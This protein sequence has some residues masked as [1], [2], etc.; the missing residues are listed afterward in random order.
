MQ[1]VCTQCQAKIKVPDSAAGKKGKCPK[2][3]TILTIPAA[4]PAPTREMQAP[5]TGMMAEAPLP[6]VDVEAEAADTDY[7]PPVSNRP[8]PV[9]KPR[10]RDMDDPEDEYEDDVSR[11][12][13]RDDDDDEPR[14]RDRDDLDILRAKKPSIG[15]SLTSM[16]LG[17][18]A[19]V[20]TLLSTVAGG[21]LGLLCP[22]GF[23]GGYV[24]VGISGILAVVSLA[25][26][27]FGLSKGGKG[28]AITGLIT[29]GLSVLLILLYVVL[30]L[31]G[32]GL[33]AAFIAANQ[34]P[35]PR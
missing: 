6:T 5:D 34:P 16:I 21:L 13:D 27:F 11:R 15:L 2:C 18:A 14:R 26:G 32:I 8:P 3:G 23:I 30:S 31:L 20:I 1:I 4:P 7:A 33:F 25:L 29:S 22:C 9:S 17:I 24:G 28:F 12:R 35:P 19:I 10:R